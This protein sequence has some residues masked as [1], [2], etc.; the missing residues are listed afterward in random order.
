MEFNNKEIN[1][2]KIN[3][4][5][6]EVFANL[7]KTKATIM[8]IKEG[9]ADAIYTQGQGIACHAL[10]LKIYNSKGE[11]EYDDKEVQLIGVCSELCS[12]AVMDGIK[13]MIEKGKQEG[14]P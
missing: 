11:E 8:N 4:E 1:K 14:Q 10:A 3:F 5:K 9:F 6:V 12:P 13:S 7:A 2:M